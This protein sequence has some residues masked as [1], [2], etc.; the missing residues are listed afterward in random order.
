MLVKRY[1]TDG[2]GL[3]SGPDLDLRLRIVNEVSDRLI[4]VAM[5]QPDRAARGTIVEELKRIVG[6]CLFGT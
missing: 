3:S 4:G 6:F 2:L 1:L 5:E